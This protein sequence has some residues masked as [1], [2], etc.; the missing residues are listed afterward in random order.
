MKITVDE[1]LSLS[2]QYAVLTEK[3]ISLLHQEFNSKDLLL[4]MKKGLFPKRGILTNGYEYF[5]HGRGCCIESEHFEVD[6][7][8]ELGT[9]NDVIRGFD[10]WRLQ[11]FANSS[12]TWK[13][14]NFDLEEIKKC[15]EQ[16]HQQGKLLKTGETFYAFPK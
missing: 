2:H 14:K 5:F 15:L 7:D 11:I 8:F 6:F 1:V 12:A 16:A 3:M 13:T 4:D 9:K 10:A